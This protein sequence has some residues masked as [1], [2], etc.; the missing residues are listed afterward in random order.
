MGYTLPLE[1]ASTSTVAV[2]AS[3]SPAENGA[4]LRAAYAQARALTPNGAALAADN[5]ATVLVGPG[6]YHLGTLDGDTHGL[7]ID[8][9]FVDLVGLT[10]RPEHVR[11]EATSD[12]STAS[13][14]TIEQTA[15]DVLIAGVTMYLDG[16]DYSQ[17]YEEGDP[18]AYFPGDNLPNTVLRDCVFEADN[19]ARYTRP[20]QE[21]SGTYIRC[22]GGAGTFAVGAQASGT[23]TDCV[24]AEETFGYYADA[25][26]VFT[27]CVAGW[28][29]FGWYADASGT[30]IDCTS[31][32]WYV[33][34]WTASGTFI[35]CTAADSAFGAEGG[36]TGK[37]YSCRLTS[38]G[39][40]F[41]T[42][43]ADS[44]GLL[45]LCIDGD[46]NEDNTGPITS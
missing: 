15:D 39:A 43:E 30:F 4:V 38:P 29:A 16:G 35:R 2:R 24:V 34:G 31:T 46:D 42:P 25:S 27:R 18:S 36:L 3:G 20:E 10:G 32:N 13:R 5:R 33:F 22:I 37:L 21:Y 6:V 40:T 8:T 12:G 26:G 17:G 41:P 14:G 9:E 44:G 1:L 45:R 28:Y 23:F 11:I 19:D 7:Q